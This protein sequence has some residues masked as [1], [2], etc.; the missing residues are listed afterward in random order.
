MVSAHSTAETRKAT[1][2]LL[3]TIVVLT[4]T[5]KPLP[6]EVL[7]TMKLLY[8]D[9]GIVLFITSF[10]YICPLKVTPPDYQP[11]GFKHTDACEFLFKQEPLNIKV[12]DVSTV[13]NNINS[14]S[15]YVCS[16]LVVSHVSYCCY[17]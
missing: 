8:Y 7:M 16:L 4:Q 6:D 10:N 17:I 3:R 2:K 12:G 13:I 11:P 14:I 15:L 1:I 9:D 5:L